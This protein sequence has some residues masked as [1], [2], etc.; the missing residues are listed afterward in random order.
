MPYRPMHQRRL[1]RRYRR[2]WKHN[3][4]GRPG[5]PPHAY[6]QPRVLQ[7]R[8]SAADRKVIDSLHPLQY[9]APGLF[10]TALR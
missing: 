4:Q 6:W 7:R 3:G 10:H 8:E 1:R 5:A 2:F 9:S